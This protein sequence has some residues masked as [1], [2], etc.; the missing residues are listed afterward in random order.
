MLQ[1]VVG[2]GEEREV[3][4]HVGNVWSE[5]CCLYTCMHAYSTWMYLRTFVCIESGVVNV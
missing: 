2:G 4:K 5:V 3:R 1:N